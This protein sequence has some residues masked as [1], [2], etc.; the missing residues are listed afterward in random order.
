MT[1]IGSNDISVLQ[2]QVTFDISGTNPVVSLVNLSQGPHLNNVVYAFLVTSPTGTYIHNGNINTPD[3]T[4]VWS[5]W[6]LT[7]PWPRPFNQIEW[8]GAQYSFTAIAKDSAGN[9]YTGT[10]QLAGI[11]RPN[12]NYPNSKTMYGIASSDVNVKCQDARILFQDTTYHSYKG[13]EGTIVSSTLKVIYPIDETSNIPDPFQIANYSTALVPISYNSNNYQFIQTTKYDY[14]LGNYTIV[15]IRYQTIQTFSVWCNIDLLPLVCEFNKL[16]D[17]LQSGSCSDVASAS[18]KVQL[19]T[20]KMILVNIGIQ[21]PLTGVDVPTLIEE[22]KEIGGFECDCCSAP[23]GII[24]TTASIIDGYSFSIVKTGGDVNG[25][26]TTT[27]SNIQFNLHDV[28]YIVT[29]GVNSPITT[30][31]FSFLPVVSGDGFTKTYYLNVDGIHLGRDILV[32]I[33]NDPYSLNYLKNLVGVPDLKLLVDGACIFNSGISCNYTFNLHNIPANTTYAILSAIGITGTGHLLSM[34]FNQTNLPALQTYLNSLGYGTFVVTNTGGGIVS[35]TSSNNTNNITSLSY[36]IASVNYVADYNKNCTGYVPLDA[37]TVVQYIIN[38]LCGLTDAQVSTSQAYS[39]CYIDP[40]TGLKNTTVVNSG[41]HLNQLLSIL[42]NNGCTTIDY[43]KTLSAGGAS[44]EGIK[45]LFPANTNNLTHSDFILLT[46]GGVCSRLD[47]VTLG[48]DILKLGIYDSDFISA[49]CTAVAICGSSVECPTLINF[50]YNFSGSSL[51]ITKIIFATTPTSPQTVSILYKL[52]SSG[53]Y[54]LYSSAVV[55]N[56]DGTIPTPVVI[57]IVSG[58]T[59]NVQIFD[60][61]NSPADGVI[62]TISTTGTPVSGSYKLGN[63]SATVCATGPVTLYTN[64]AFAIGGVLY[65]DSGLTNPVTGNLFVVNVANN[66]IYNL[67]NTTGEVGTDTGILCSV[68][69]TLTLSFISSGSF[70]SFAASL[71]Q[72]INSNISIDR[73]FTDGYSDSGCT[74]SVASAQQNIAWGIATG[75]TNSSTGCQVKTGVWSSAIKYT[76]YNIIVN[77]TNIT[78]NG[79]VLTIGGDVVTV[80]FGSCHVI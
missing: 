1:I 49:F 39:V 42:I 46:K 58:S 47:P 74:I 10:P 9:V 45:S 48:T 19:I 26:V 43:I 56:I 64:G 41:T 69:A 65:T 21:Q 16:I 67:N 2:V 13:D 31:A 20:S 75:S 68:A 79:Q 35:I 40:V 15:R 63:N 38:Y 66:H 34:S 33:G 61:C 3:I 73:I 62:K 8:S 18:M 30:T 6:T 60:N 25:N 22:I 50:Q 32:N 24:P 28:S 14:D 80:N 51:N 52:S 78:S 23:S 72:A 4:G 29:I 11:C 77:G 55:V 36:S 17:L 12:G 27:G 54:T 76:Q 59:Y 7:D 37:N 5:T 70:Q 44:C 71:S 53:T 57:P